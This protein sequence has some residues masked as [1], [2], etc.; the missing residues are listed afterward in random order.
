MVDLL[1]PGTLPLLL[2]VAGIIVSILEAIAP[3]ANFIVLGIALIITGLV[4][5]LFPSSASPL[6]LAGVIL[7][8]GAATLIAYRQLDFYGGKGEGRTQDSTTLVG[9]EGEVEQ[10]VTRSSGRV[11]LYEGGF[12]PTFSARTDGE[13]IEEGRTVV[14]VDPGGGSILTVAPAK[15]VDPATLPTGDTD[16]SAE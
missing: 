3:G 14:V 10:R 11:R 13:P 16:E 8:V 7:V 2:V 15:D 9:R 1:D 12:D 5:L 6:I 4:G